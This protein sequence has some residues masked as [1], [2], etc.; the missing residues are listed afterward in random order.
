MYVDDIRNIFRYK[1]KVGDFF[2]DKTGCKVIEI[3]GAS[4]I[5]DEP[6][7]FGTPNPQYIN[8]VLDML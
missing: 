4:F 2:I 6:S 8:A 7:I 5:A 1:L 3:L